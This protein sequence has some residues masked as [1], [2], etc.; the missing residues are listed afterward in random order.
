[1]NAATGQ[2]PG[3][4]EKSK[5]SRVLHTLNGVLK[6]R[7]EVVDNLGEDIGRTLISVLVEQ[8]K[9]QAPFSDREVLN[10]SLFGAVMR[11][12]LAL[13]RFGGLANVHEALCRARC[14]LG[15][16]PGGQGREGKDTYTTCCSVTTLTLRC[17]SLG[18]AAGST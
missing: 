17:R 9:L 11:E 15:N 13:R 7:V 6:G 8:E 3:G 1:V 16:S 14:A 4:N 18:P 10:R 2:Q 12:S 5:K